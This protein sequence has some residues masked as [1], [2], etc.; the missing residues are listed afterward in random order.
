[1]FAHRQSSKHQIS[2]LPCFIFMFFC[3]PGT[4][5]FAI[6]ILVPQDVPSIIEAID[7][8]QDGDVIWVSPGDY[9][10]PI[11]LMGKS[12]QLISTSGPESTWIS[13]VGQSSAVKFISGEFSNTILEG[14]TLRNG[15]GTVISGRSYGGGILI[16]N[17]TPTIRNCIIENNQAVEGGGIHIEGPTFGEVILES[18]ILQNNSASDLGGGLSLASQAEINMSECSLISN[19][20]SV[21]SG[22]ISCDQSTLIVSDSL[23]ANNSSNLAV[24]AVWVHCDSE[25]VITDS[26]ISANTAPLSGGGIVISDQGRATLDRCQISENSGGSSGGGILLDSGSDQELQIIRDCVF[27][28]NFAQTGGAHL[29]VS[30]NPINLLI[31]SCTFGLT[32]NNSG[33]AININNSTPDSIIIDSSIVM[34]S[35]NGSVVAL[36]GSTFAQ[37]SCI[38]GM[39]GSG[40]SQ[41]D[42]FDLDPLFTDAAAGIYTLEPGSPCLDNGNPLLPLDSDGS[43]TDVGALGPRTNV[44]EEFRRGDVDGSGTENI[45]DAIQVLAFLFIPG[46]STPP[47]EDAVD[48]NDDGALNLTD[49]ITLLT[50]LFVLGDPLPVPFGECGLDPTVDSLTCSTGCP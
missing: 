12:I 33:A 39:L 37:Y 15:T 25:A 50:T 36:P 9:A 31:E 6:E 48:T 30:F 41:L 32:S 2:F 4:L 34:G 47:C 11:D 46:A 44:S 26:V 28:N 35:A 18:V 29:S 21:V 23:I 22:A 5:L 45:A 42:S 24:G 7:A 40:V 43:I 8:A 1:M 49:A 19:T 17:S 10:G 14:F 13:V 3:G 20:A 27:H 16:Q 38:E